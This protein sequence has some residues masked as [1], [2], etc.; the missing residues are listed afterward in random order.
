MDKEVVYR[1]L[2]QILYESGIADIF[3]LTDGDL[4]DVN[5]SKI[6]EIIGFLYQAGDEYT[7]SRRNQKKMRLEGE[8]HLG[9][10]G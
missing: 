2:G 3:D 5:S 7:F 6:Q 4:L 9:F 10:V 1:R 8:R